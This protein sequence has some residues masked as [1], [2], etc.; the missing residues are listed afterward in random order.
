MQTPPLPFSS[1][2]FTL[3]ELGEGVFAAIAI[4]GGSAISN[5]GIIDLGERTLVFDTF[6]TPEAGAD[7][8]AAARQVTGREPALV[9]NSHYHNDHIWGNQ[10]FSP[11]TLFISTARTLELMQTAGRDE[12]EWAQDIGPDGLGRSRQHYESAA[13]EFTRRDALMWTGYYGG[14][15]QALSTLSVRF[16]DVTFNGRLSINGSARSVELIPFANSHTAEDLI[17]HLPDSGI[18]FMADLLFVGCHPYL[19][20]AEIPAL[21]NTL[22]E[23]SS[24]GAPTL[25]P[26]HGP[27]GAQPD[28]VSNLDYISMCTDAAMHLIATGDTSEER[29]AGVVPPEPFAHW[30]LSRFFAANLESLCAR[31][32]AEKQAS[33]QGS[34]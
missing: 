6:M 28:I 27:L 16:P 24:W 18:V 20:E 10:A 3:H 15:V 33:A 1:P 8:R 31:F 9:V 32:T 12:I 17:M 29:I 34:G 14:L 13:D 23:I 26:G 7:L 11:Q 22:A 21:R 25:V 30:G 5:A 19:D 2:H 4:D